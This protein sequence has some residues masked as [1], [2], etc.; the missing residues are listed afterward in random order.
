MSSHMYK[1]K[2][3]FGPRVAKILPLVLC[4]HERHDGKDYNGMIGRAVPV[5]ARVIAVADVYDAITTDRPYRKAIT[6]RDGL[7]KIEAGRGT[8][9]DL[10]VVKAFIH[11]FDS[12][13]ATK[14][15]M[16]NPTEVTEVVSSNFQVNLPS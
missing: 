2:E 16:R 12:F 10:K 5:G 7:R 8:Q 1:S 15:L 14:P 6:P 11:V 3:I 9:F 13:I 4:H